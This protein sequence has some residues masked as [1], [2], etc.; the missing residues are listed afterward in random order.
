MLLVCL[1]H[2]LPILGYST[3]SLSPIYAVFWNIHRL[4]P[5]SFQAQDSLDN[6]LFSFQI[7]V[8]L[9]KEEL[10]SAESAALSKNF[11]AKLQEV[12]F[13]LNQDITQLVRD[14]EPIRAILR[15]LE[16]KLPESVK[17]ALTPAAFI[18]SYRVQVLKA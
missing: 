8:T 5:F 1:I 9:P 18:E 4:T 10:S 11:K 16:G 15:T 2:H 14:A 7:G 17:E 13:F 6:S 3:R 12:L